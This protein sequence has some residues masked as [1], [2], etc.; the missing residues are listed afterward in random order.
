MNLLGKILTVLIFVMALVC[1]GFIVSVYSTHVNWR[2]RVLV[3]QPGKPSLKTQLQDEKERNTELAEQKT[4]IEAQLAKEKNTA[5]QA[6]AKLQTENDDQAQTIATQ[7]DDLKKL[8]ES[9]RQAAAAMDATHATLKKTREELDALRTKIR[10]AEA[11]RD[12]RFNEVVALT[13][14]MHQSVSE[15]K[16]LKSRQVTLAMDLA[17]AKEVLDKHGLVPEP[18]RYAEVAPRVDGIV[19]AGTDGD[20]IE[21]S[22]GSDD[23]LRKGHK[24]EVFRLKDGDSKYL[25]RVEVL[26]T[27]VDKAACKILPAFRKGKIQRGD[28]VASQLD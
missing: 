23:G 2:N 10:E 25:G 11:D 17:K 1:M 12:K 14:T 7:Q 20:V 8:R 27:A 5:R 26:K 13:D 19:L 21:I 28:R 22:L 15:L 3:D 4:K 9:E 18:T 6:L 16:R 24:L